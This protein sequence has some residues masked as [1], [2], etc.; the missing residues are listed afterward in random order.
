MHQDARGGERSSLSTP[1]LRETAFKRRL[2]DDGLRGA[3]WNI[4]HGDDGD[5]PAKLPV[6]GKLAIAYAAHPHFDRRWVRS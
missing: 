2:V 5:V 1:G 3:T 6:L 4:G